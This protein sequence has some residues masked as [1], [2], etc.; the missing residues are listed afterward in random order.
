MSA[1]L[2]QQQRRDEIARLVMKYGHISVEALSERTGVS[3]MTIYRDLGVLE[4]AG[5]LSRS[6]GKVYA[7]ASGLHEA[8]ARYRLEQ[9]NTE[10]QA[11]ALAAAPLIPPTGSL[12]V[13]DSTSSVWLLRELMGQSQLSVVTNSLLVAAEL[14]NSTR[15]SLYLLGGEYQPWA[16]ATMGPGTIAAL[17]DIYADVCVI[18]ASG[19]YEGVVY[20]PYADVAAVKKKMIS[21]AGRTIMLLDHT[22]F[23]RRA[24]H[25]FGKLSDIHTVVVDH[26]TTTQQVALLEEYGVKVVRATAETPLEKNLEQK[27]GDVSREGI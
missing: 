3:S 1:G 10:K 20:Q 25:A 5:V 9:Q 23:A 4:E 11:I 21:R 6:A 26:I 12:L 13:D 24:L 7:T 8:A 22:K 19:L 14:Q 2:D 15:H 17:E 16:Q 27:G 18:S